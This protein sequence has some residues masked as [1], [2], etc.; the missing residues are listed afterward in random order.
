MAAHF[1]QDGVAFSYPENWQMLHED[2]PSGWAV[3]LESPDAADTAFLI[4]RYDGDMPAPD[5]VAEQP[6][7]A[8]G[9]LV[10]GHP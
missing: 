10:H 2:S 9:P 6:T 1:D 3:T 7:R 5:D 8:P 4:V